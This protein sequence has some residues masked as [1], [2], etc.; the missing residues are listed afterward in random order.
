MNATEERGREEL[1]E[2]Q[3]LLNV[4]Q[5][6]I[7]N[8]TRVTNGTGSNGA[9][10]MVRCFPDQCGQRKVFEALARL[11]QRVERPPALMVEE[12]TTTL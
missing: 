6:V 11:E 12:V 8:Y 4:V 10:E 5:L 2:T 3:G 9:G 7:E 1:H